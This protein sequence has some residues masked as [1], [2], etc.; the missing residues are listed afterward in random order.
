MRAGINKIAVGTL[1]ATFALIW[2]APFLYS[3]WTSFH[4][5]RYSAKLQWDAPFT[6]ENFLTAWSAAP[7]ALYFA[8]TIVMTAV[9]LIANLI[10]CTLVAYAFTRYRFPGAGVLFAFVMITLLI[11]PDIL[12]VENYVTMGHLGLVDTILGIAFPYLTSAFGIFL[13]RQTFK[14]VPLSLDEAAQMEGASTWRVLWNVYVPLAKPTY[15]AYSLVA[16]S[17]HWNNFLW[18][19][20]VTKSPESR[21]VTV[22]LKVFALV[23]SGIEWSIVNAAAL[24]TTAPLIIAFLLF[25]KQFVANFMRA[26][27]K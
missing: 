1:A 16:I 13:L 12:I 5:D 20:I 22:G 18:P 27:I 25:Q 24:M 15:I 17:A 23:D 7:F 2:G 11:T 10:L 3:L 19:L 4:P 6:F 14:T 26:G 9:I 21:P 8:N